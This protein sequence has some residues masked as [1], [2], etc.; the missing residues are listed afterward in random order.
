[1]GDGKIEHS[2]GASTAEDEGKGNVVD[3]GEVGE[4]GDGEGGGH[5]SVLNSSNQSTLDISVGD[6]WARE[7][8]A[9]ADSTSAQYSRVSDKSS[10]GHQVALDTYRCIFVKRFRQIYTNLSLFL[11]L[12]ISF[13][14]SLPLDN[15][16][17][18][19]DP[20]S[21]LEERIRWTHPPQ[22][23]CV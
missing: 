10:A 18:E 23:A 6:D 9:E 14:L 19:R 16:C 11:S 22:P 15:I 12:S 20:N 3:E 1:M 13:S 17:T 21:P 8:A 4:L 7:G 2:G 5:A